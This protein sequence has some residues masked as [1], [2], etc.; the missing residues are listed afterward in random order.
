LRPWSEAIETAEGR[1]IVARQFATIDAYISSF[2]E[3]IQVSLLEVRR[4]IRSA[5][6]TATETISY[7][8]PTISLDGKLV[9]YFAGWKHHLSLYPLPAVDVAFEQELRPYRAGKSTMRFPLR[10]PIPYDLIERLVALRVKQR[11][12][13]GNDRYRGNGSQ[14]AGA[15]SWTA[16]ITRGERIR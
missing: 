13:S 10:K 5:V 3:D 16:A 11:V 9:V 8:I 7:Q 14:Q 6:P 2:P 1:R 12:A 4:T 15:A